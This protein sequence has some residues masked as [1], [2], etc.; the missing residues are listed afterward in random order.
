MIE[1]QKGKQVKYL[2]TDN[3]LEFCSNEF[4]V[5]CKSEGIVRHLTVPYTPQQNGVAERMNRTIMEKVR[6]MLSNAHLPKSF[7]AEVAATTCFL[8]NR[9]PSTAIEKKTPKEVWSGTPA[10]YSD[11]NIFCCPTYTHVDNMKNWSLDL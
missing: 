5:L 3:G 9:S 11:L 8:I 6:C 7:W 2:R 1:K 4:N 10:N